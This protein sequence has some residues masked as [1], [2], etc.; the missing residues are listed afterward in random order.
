M[1]TAVII[2]GQPRNVQE[3]FHNINEF[4]LKPN[5]PDVFIHSWISENIYKVLQKYKEIFQQHIIH[6]YG[7]EYLDYV[8]NITKSLI[9]SLIPI[10]NNDKCTQYFKLINNC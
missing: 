1:K 2:S 3:N 10:H 6:A 5:N 4:I 7:D 8:I 9:I